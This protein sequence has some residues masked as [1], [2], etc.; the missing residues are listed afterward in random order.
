MNQQQDKQDNFLA[1]LIT[2]GEAGRIL[3]KVP[4]TVN[5]YHRIGRL[6][7]VRISNGMRLFNRRQVERL[8]EQMRSK[9]SEEGK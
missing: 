7:A 8:A 9:N 1:D 3:G 2:K 4:A 5:Y 6:E